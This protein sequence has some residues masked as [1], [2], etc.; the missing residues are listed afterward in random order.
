M[1]EGMIVYLN[2]DR[3]ATE[4]NESLIQRMDDLLLNFGMPDRVRCRKRIL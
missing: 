1:N 2:L 4:E 3:D